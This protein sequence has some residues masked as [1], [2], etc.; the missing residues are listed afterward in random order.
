MYLAIEKVTK[1]YGDILAVNEVTTKWESNQI[2]GLVGPNGAGKTT[3]LKTVSG[4]LEPSN[5]RIL[6]N[7]KRVA[8]G[9]VAY[10]PEFPDLFPALSVWEHCKF[11]ALAYSIKG[12]ELHAQDYLESLQLMD[13]RDSLVGELSKGMKQKVMVAI[14]LLRKPPVLLMD[15]PFS[16]LDPLSSRELQKLIVD[17]KDRERIIVVSSH[18]L[19][20]IQAICNRV[21]IM[22]QGSVLK[23]QEMTDILA[24]ARAKGISTLEDYFLEVTGYGGS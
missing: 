19:N 11:I 17:I 12:W 9:A 2:I 1:S 16:G 6:L 4:F 20:T 13:K 14:T 10:V 7:G 18:N 8:M 22:N 24:E 21:L 15:E 5:G 3:L 23:E